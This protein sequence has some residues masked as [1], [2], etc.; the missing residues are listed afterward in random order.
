MDAARRKAHLEA[1]KERKAAAGI[2]AVRCVPS[3]EIWVGRAPDLDTIWRRLSFELT[4]RGCRR[5]SLQ[6]AWEAHGSSAFSFEP[7]ERI[8]E[9]VAYVR[10]RQL[11]ARLDHWRQALG[12]QPV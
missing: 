2:Y 8:E 12:A 11:A 1:Y 7:L 4:Q 6:A 9:E 5:V 10:D 3:G